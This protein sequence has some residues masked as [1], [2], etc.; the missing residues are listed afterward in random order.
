MPRETPIERL[1]RELQAAAVRQ[2]AAEPS[3]PSH[4]HRRWPGRTLAAT[5]LAAVTVTGAASWAATSLLSSGSP[6][7]FQRGAPI[8]GQAHGAP[9]PGT[10]K[11]L[12]DDVADPDGGPPWGLRYWETDR[13]YAC[14]QVGRV[15][16]GKLG[17]VS[18]KVFHELRLGVT[19][20]ILGGCFALDGG[21]HAFTA[22]HT[23][24]LRGAQATV[25]PEGFMPGTVLKGL[26]GR[27]VRCPEPERTID[28]GLLGPN[29]Q[30]LTY[31]A[32]G[33]ERT[34]APLGGVGA[35]LVVQRRIKPVTREYGFHHRDPKL[36]LR[37][38][39]EPYLAL[40][41][42]SQVMQRITYKNGTCVVRITTS[43]YGSCNVQAGFVPIPQPR[44]ADVRTPVRA[45]AAPDGRGIRVRFRARQAVI[46]GR[47]GY[48]IELRPVGSR[49]V[50]TQTYAHN[51][52]A[53][54]LVH[55]TI[56][57]PLP[58]RAAYTIVV[59]YRMVRPRPGP[60]ATLAYPGL[61][62]GRAR[63]DMR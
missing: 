27:K 2:L 39:A 13:K 61:L 57:L 55:T 51:V 62:V 47:S 60:Y 63:V 29:A 46:D 48:D 25:C 37:G 38:P 18:G 5:L 50:L 24:S 3:V 11:L 53:G 58:R 14:V 26:H 4:R 41:P 19:R 43:P 59:R 32:G 36:N 52:K 1:G 56:D 23:D 42:A 54:D 10:V 8:A 7:P 22:I 20:G 49:N 15:D 45:F 9:I 33:R 28:F 31:R 21:G 34:V 40:T 16:R 12:A 44:V 35:Y 30:R 17:Q 6:V